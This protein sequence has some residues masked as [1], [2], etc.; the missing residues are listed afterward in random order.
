MGIIE[1][2]CSQWNSCYQCSFFNITQFDLGEANIHVFDN[3]IKYFEPP[4]FDPFIQVYVDGKT[5]LFNRSRCCEGTRILSILYDE[6]ESTTY[7]GSTSRAL[8]DT[9]AFTDNLDLHVSTVSNKT[10]PFLL[11]PL[12]PKSETVTL[13]FLVVALVGLIVILGSILLICYKRRSKACQERSNHVY[14]AANETNRDA[15]AD[16]STLG[17]SAVFVESLTQH[18]TLPMMNEA[19]SDNY[20]IIES[21]ETISNAVYNTLSG[22]SDSEQG[23]YDVIQ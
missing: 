20:L 10:G 23:I 1:K 7:S 12:D 14:F 16:Y 17:E 5:I 3:C 8:T 19:P 6:G 11:D 18:R 21:N 4:S 13:S 22:R 9:I 15:V 2:T